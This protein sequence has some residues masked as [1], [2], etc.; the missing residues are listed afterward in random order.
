MR[1][2]YC[3]CYGVVLLFDHA[4]A[5]DFATKG[6]RSCEI[7]GRDEKAQATAEEKANAARP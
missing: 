6:Q 4:K 7:V 2:I 1:Y 5:N 3:R